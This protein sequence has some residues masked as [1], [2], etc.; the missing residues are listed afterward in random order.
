ME[1]RVFALLLTAIMLLTMI[2]LSAATSS[3]PTSIK[4]P[5]SLIASETEYET[6]LFFRLIQS[7]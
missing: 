3:I 2:P 5:G 1:K 4:A 6:E 7:C